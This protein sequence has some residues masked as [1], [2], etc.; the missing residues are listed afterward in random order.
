MMSIISHKALKCNYFEKLFTHVRRHIKTVHEG[1]NDFKCESCEKSFTQADSLRGHIKS[2]HE[3]QKDF[4]CDS[5]GKLFTCA[6][7]MRRHIKTVQM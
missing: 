1:C 7:N 5:C 2:I 6:G 4:K 3:G